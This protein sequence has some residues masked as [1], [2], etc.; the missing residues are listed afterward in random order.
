MLTQFI[1][2]AL[3]KFTGPLL[4]E[5]L[6]L[7]IYTVL[8]FMSFRYLLEALTPCVD[9]FSC[10]AGILAANHFVYMGF[11]NFSYSV[12]LLLFT[13]GYYVRQQQRWTVQSLTML[14]IGGLSVY[15][16][17]ALSWVVC[18]AAVAIL[19][20][21]QMISALLG[22][23]T[24]PLSTS[25]RRV[26]L[27]YALPFWSLL[28]P[29]F[30]MLMY[31][32]HSQEESVSGAIIGT[33]LRQRLWP[34]YS[35]SFL[36]AIA[37]SDLALAKAVATTLFIALAFV[38]GV[39]LRRRQYNWRSTAVLVLSLTCGAIAVLGPDSVGSG[40][41]IH[42][43]VAL[44][45]WL[46]LVVWLALQSWPRWALNIIS[47]VFCGMAVI[48]LAAR[49]PVLSRWN[50]ELS[51]FVAV[52][53]SI[54][55]RSTVLGFSLELP[56]GRVN[57][58]LHAVGLLS[59]RAIIDLGNYEAATDYFSTRFQPE[60]T[61]FPALGTPEQLKARPPVFD[62]VRYEK[63]T[64]GRVDYIIFQGGTDSRGNGIERPEVRLYG[65]QIATYTLVALGQRGN[66]RLYQ[67]I[68]PDGN[69]N[70]ARAKSEPQQFV[71]GYR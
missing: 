19:G 45:A 28:P 56:E 15:L 3:L 59:S 52:G 65:D 18:V 71:G 9:Y 34:L 8:L 27:Q 32:M 25:V 13:V 54:R 23:R 61:P 47:A 5:K 16:T 44:Y 42:E 62:I 64:H 35:L 17:H 60:R 40:F 69:D 29:G 7:T 33:S 10:F 21:P 57:P 48:S 1:L 24:R 37:G 12:C 2:A 67:R 31:F 68:S 50:E 55:P 51:D 39:T 38:V 14:S 70:M 49:V 66:V 11:W 6:L 26:T 58:Y 63:E 20:L 43:R 4:A 22:R 30:F 41:L 36:N 46:F 53:Q